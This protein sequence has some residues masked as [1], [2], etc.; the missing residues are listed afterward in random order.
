MSATKLEFQ[1]IDV[2]TSTKYTGNQLAIVHIPP[3]L[4]DTITQEQKLSVAREFNLSETI[5]MHDNP[6]DAA[7]DAPVRADIFTTEQELPFAG[8]PT[9][10]SSWY[11]LAGPGSVGKERKA[12]TLKTKAGPIRAVLQE[13]GRV[14]EQVPLDFK[15]HEPI[16]ISWF[17]SAQPNL[18]ATDFASGVDG[19]DA[20]ASVVKGVNFVLLRVNSEEALKNLQTV[21]GIIDIPW[22]GEW[23]GFVALYAFYEREDGVVRTRFFRDTWEDAATGAAASTLGGWLGK[24]KG[25]GKWKIEIVQGVEVGRRS[26]IEVQVEVGSDGNVKKVELGGEAVLVMEGAIVV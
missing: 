13:S 14:L 4:S 26:E 10:G 1:V 9:V 22:L 7:P 3:M 12:I 21:P 15:E 8:H 6:P 24:R 17:K 23:Q 20:V 16:Q 2:F 18:Q 5:F 19:K 25:E 11:L